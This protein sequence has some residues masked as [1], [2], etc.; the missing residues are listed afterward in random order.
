MRCRLP[1]GTTCQNGVCACPAGQTLCGGACTDLTTDAANCGQCGNA[2]A[3]GASC[4]SGT[5]KTCTVLYG[6][7]VCPQGCSYDACSPTA[8]P[9]VLD[10]TT[11][12]CACPPGYTSCPPGPCSSESGRCTGTCLPPDLHGGSGNC[13]GC[14]IR[15]DSAAGFGCGYI[16]PG[17]PACRCATN[18]NCPPEHPTCDFSAG[19]GVCV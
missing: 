14:G 1:G 8:V 11:C 18:A 17:V 12:E 4:V 6:H 3:T 15:C 7:V 16:A 10:P 5:C 9:G 13:G 19:F 2:C